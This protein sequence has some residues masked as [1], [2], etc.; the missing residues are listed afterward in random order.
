MELD[1]T[2]AIKQAG[3]P[4]SFEAKETVAP[5]EY[6]GRMITFAAP[7]H[8]Q[9]E[10]VF[11]GKGVSL[12]AKADTVLMAQCARCGASFHQ[13]YAFDVSERFTK[14]SGLRTE[15]EC[16]PYTGNTLVLD[17]A[18]M[19]NFY[20]H[21]PITSLCRADCKGLCPVCGANRNETECTCQ[22]TEAGGPFS[23]LASLS[24]EE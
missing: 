3:E 4:F 21:L 13:P 7:L 8:A 14:S 5:Q 20:L 22:P 1:I 18:V 10:Y 24:D 2:A 12:K 16:Y 17:Q 6:G 19:D 9:G 15:E 11:D 23:V